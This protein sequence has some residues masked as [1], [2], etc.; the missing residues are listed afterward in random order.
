MT[1]WVRDGCAPEF[2]RRRAHPELRGTTLVAA[3]LSESEGQELSALVRKQRKILFEENAELL[4]EAEEKRY[5][6]LV[7]VSAGDSELF[8]KKRRERAARE[9]VRA[10]GDER[11]VASLPRRPQLAE[12]GSIELPRIPLA[13]R[14][15]RRGVDG[16]RRRRLGRDPGW[17]SPPNED[18]AAR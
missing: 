7:G 16:R 4:T 1:G 2:V 13:R 11:R 15:Q 5:E 9:K 8:P 17:S 6:Q 14:R 3:H 18:R 10:L 12:A